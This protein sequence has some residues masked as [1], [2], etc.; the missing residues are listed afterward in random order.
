MSTKKSVKDIVKEKYS[1][2]AKQAEIDRCCPPSSCCSSDD[3]E[4]AA[5]NDNYKG[6][7]GYTPEAD[8]QLGCGIPT[9]Y[10]G[11]N[12]ND[13]VVDLGCGAGNDVFVARSLVGTNGKVI[14]I[15]MTEKMIIKA[16]RNLS[17]LGYKNVEFKLGEIENTPIENNSVDVVLSNCVLN[18]VPDKEKAFAEIYRILISGGHFCISDIVVK[19]NLPEGL[20]R[21]A[22]LYTGCIAGAINRDDYLRIISDAGFTNVEIK[23]S[24]KIPLPKEILTNYLNQDEI[25]PFKNNAVGIFSITVVGFKV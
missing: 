17:K 5:M 3:S 2:I 12:E 4:C 8:L 21:S 14:G 9:K 11:I 7:D 1:E 13:T 19:G 25:I 6:L 20:K 22:A 24:K 15:D 10:A 18:L 16:Q 23:V